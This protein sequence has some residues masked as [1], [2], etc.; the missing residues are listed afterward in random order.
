MLN[1]D[2]VRPY[3]TEGLSTS[4]ALSTGYVS[5]TAGD[6]YL[7]LT[8]DE[9]TAPD[10]TI[11]GAAGDLGASTITAG[12]AGDFDNLREGDII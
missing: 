5:T 11:T 8:I 2:I 3:A 7:P 9:F 1:I 10:I 4:L 12:T 6:I